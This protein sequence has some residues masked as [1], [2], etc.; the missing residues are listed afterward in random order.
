M[1]IVGMNQLVPVKTI[2]LI[3]LIPLSPFLHKAEHPV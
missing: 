1:G 2:S 3:P